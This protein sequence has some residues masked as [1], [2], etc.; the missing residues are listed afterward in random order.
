MTE[1]ERDFPDDD[2]VP[3]AIVDQNF[4][5]LFNP[6]D[7]L[8]EP[9]PPELGYLSKEE[10]DGD[11]T[12][13][14]EAIFYIPITSGWRRFLPRRY[15]GYKRRSVMFQSGSA[16]VR[17][18]NFLLL[19]RELVV[20][21]C[22]PVC[23]AFGCAARP[24]GFHLYAPCCTAHTQVVQEV[25]NCIRAQFSRP[26]DGPGTDGKFSWYMTNR[27]GEVVVL[28][29]E[30]LAGCPASTDK[31]SPRPEFFIQTKPLPSVRRVKSVTGWQHLVVNVALVS[32]CLLW[33][34]Q[35]GWKRLPGERHRC[36]WSCSVLCVVA[37]L[38]RFGCVLICLAAGR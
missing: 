12:A 23:G 29:T 3:S 9:L 32:L 10:A 18:P 31:A 13:V 33:A 25:D 7:K 36:S 27:R 34:C 4:D 6:D 26:L 24:T 21:V 38:S 2:I 17:H 1:T 35:D 20:L 37:R 5:V 30:L 14:R 28:S 11:A 22:L 8:D 15:G 19:R 16:K